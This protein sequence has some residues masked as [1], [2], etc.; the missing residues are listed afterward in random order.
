MKYAILRTKDNYREVNAWAA[1]NKAKGC[2]FDFVLEHG[3]VIVE[4]GKATA[5]TQTSPI[6]YGHEIISWEDFKGLGRTL[7]TNYKLIRDYPG[8]PCKVGE[9][10]P[11]TFHCDPTA[12]P[13]IWEKDF[14]TGD[15]V[16]VEGSDCIFIVDD[17]EP[18]GETSYVSVSP[19]GCVFKKEKLR[20][21][22]AEEIK[23][24]FKRVIKLRY[25]G[26]EF[27]VEV[28]SEG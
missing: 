27:E 3:S 18:L 21:A 20:L 9:Y 22:T 14:K 17:I 4:D 12:Y 16:V 5:T 6:P 2:I 11:T 24:H 13:E 7:R 28:S 8:A 25:E 15:K 10:L 19:G 26:G 1:A 23:K